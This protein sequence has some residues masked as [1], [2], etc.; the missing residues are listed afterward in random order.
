KTIGLYQHSSVGREIV[1]EILEKLG[2]KVILL[3]F[4]EKFVSV[5]TEAIRQEDV[6]LAKQWASK[7]KVDSKVSTDG[8]AD[9]P[10]VSDEYGNWLKVD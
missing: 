5:D 1:N 8:D 7:Y 2:A 6:K 3:E 4:S 10:L 9:R